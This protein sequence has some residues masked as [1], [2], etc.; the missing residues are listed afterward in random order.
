MITSSSLSSLPPLFHAVQCRRDP[1]SMTYIAWRVLPPDPSKC[2]SLVLL[3]KLSWR[4]GRM[5]ATNGAIRSIDEHPGINGSVWGGYTSYMQ[6]CYV[7]LI[8]MKCY[9][10]LL[11]QLPPEAPR[12]CKRKRHMQRTKYA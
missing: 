9:I 2:S 8:G 6:V 5:S 3:I 12:T 1:Y 11:Y 4:H 10:W 7:L